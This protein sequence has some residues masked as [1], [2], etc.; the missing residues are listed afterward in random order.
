MTIV[1]GESLDQLVLRG[2]AT[3]VHAIGRALV[4]LF[5][6]QTE[7]EQRD[8]VTKVHNL[9]GF[10]AGD[11][12]DGSLGALAYKKNRWLEPWQVKKWTRLNCKGRTRIGKYH[13]EQ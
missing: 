10:T 5:A 7:P 4:L 2:D 6:R 11:A 3:S 12:R 8:K 9:R 1:S 13:R